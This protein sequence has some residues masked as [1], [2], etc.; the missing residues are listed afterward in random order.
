MKKQILTLILFGN[1]L[2]TLCA[3]QNKEQNNNP[4]LEVSEIETENTNESQIQAENASKEPNESITESTEEIQ[5]EDNKQVSQEIRNNVKQMMSIQETMAAELSHSINFD[6]LS[7]A[8]MNDK[9][10]ELYEVW[11]F[12][13]NSLWNTLKETLSEDEMT[14]LT[15]E[16]REWVEM[17]E[18]SVKESGAQFEGGS[19]Y[20]LIVNLKAV[21]L[22]KER[23]YEL[24]QLIIPLDTTSFVGEYYDYDVKEPNLEIRKNEDETYAIQIGIYRLASI[25]DGVGILQDDKLVFTATDPGGKPLEGY[26]TLNGKIATVTFV[27]SEWEYFSDKNEYQYYKTSDTPFIYE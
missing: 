5:S 4:T 18:L 9:S 11:D 13:L 15:I 12:A 21:E 27:D 1:I 10:A 16:E 19:I 3:C 25:D 14:K 17:K 22:T 26:I 23:V 7:Q 8:E 20:P 6:N 24:L 2:L